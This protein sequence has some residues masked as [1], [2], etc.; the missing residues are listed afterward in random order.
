MGHY[1]LVEGHGKGVVAL[2]FVPQGPWVSSPQAPCSLPLLQASCAP[3]P[4]GHPFPL[5]HLVPWGHQ[6]PLVHHGPLVHQD[7]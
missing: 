5:V 4:C 7:P 2:A 1:R 3:Q 6:E